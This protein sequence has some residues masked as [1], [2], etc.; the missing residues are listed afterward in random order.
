MRKF[1]GILARPMPE[2]SFQE[3]HE[4]QRYLA[5]KQEKDEREA[6]L[7]RHF[8]LEPDNPEAWYHVALAL[9][10]LVVPAYKP[11]RGRPPVSNLH[12]DGWARYW[13]ALRLTGTPTDTEAFET[14]AD[15]VKADIKT[16]RTRL[17]AFRRTH[18]KDFE[19]IERLA[20]RQIANNGAEETLQFAQRQA[21]N[22]VFHLWR[23]AEDFQRIQ[24]RPL[25]PEV[26]DLA[27]LVRTTG[28][29]N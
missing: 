28:R 17:K 5:L 19:A 10:Q 8:G 4:P 23:M 21:E 6:A 13:V 16:V 3:L 29:Q 22:E 12:V 14:I 24:G 11:P 27:E 7:I 2:V 25:P 18:A 20:H 26:R 9:A 15:L 1:T